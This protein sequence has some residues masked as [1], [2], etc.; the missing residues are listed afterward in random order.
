[1]TKKDYNLIAKSLRDFH[2]ALV[3]HAP[4]TTAAYDT[5]FARNLV[6]PLAHRLRQDNPAFDFGRFL[7]ACGVKPMEAE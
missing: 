5:E 7:A 6:V 3:I 2:H 1:M 4:C